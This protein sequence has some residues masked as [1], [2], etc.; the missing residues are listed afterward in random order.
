MMSRS[1]PLPVTAPWTPTAK[2]S[3]PLSVSQR[4]AAFESSCNLVLNIS[5]YSAESI[6]FFVLRPKRTAS[7]AVWVA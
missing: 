1:A 7:S 2:Y 4:P 3:P 5:L 6:K